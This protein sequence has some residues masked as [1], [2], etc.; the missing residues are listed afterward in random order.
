MVFTLNLADGPTTR[1]LTGLIL[2]LIMLDIVFKLIKDEFTFWIISCIWFNT[3]RWNSL[4]S[5][6]TCSLPYPVDTM[7]ADA[8]ATAEARASAGMILNPQARIFHLQHHKSWHI[9]QHPF[10]PISQHTYSHN[11]TFFSYHISQCPSEGQAVSLE[12]QEMSDQSLPPPQCGLWGK[13]S[14]ITNPCHD[15]FIS[16]TKNKHL[17][18]VIS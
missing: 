2:T 4:R 9:L 7:P 13:K 6:T 3:S 15:E 18:F 10:Y 5:N 14:K 12:G 16:G 1:N 11:N 17:H 8:L